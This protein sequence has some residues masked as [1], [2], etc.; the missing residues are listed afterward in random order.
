[1]AIGISLVQKFLGSFCCLPID[2][3]LEEIKESIKAGWALL[4]LQAVRSSFNEAKSI[5]ATG[6]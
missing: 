2:C 6:M 5:K 1:M 3:Q 4:L